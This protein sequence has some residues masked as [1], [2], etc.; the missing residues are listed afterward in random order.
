MKERPILFSGPMVNAILEGRKTQ[1][2]RVVKPQ[3]LR[4]HQPDS[5][6]YCLTDYS[7]DATRMFDHEH[8]RCPHG[9]QPEQ[10]WVRETF[11][12]DHDDYADGGRLPKGLPPI[13]AKQVLDSIYYRADGE[14]CQQ[15]PECQ[16]WDVGKPKWRPSIFMP[17]WASRITLEITGV[18]VER[19][20]NIS[21]NDAWSEGVTVEGFE[22]A[23]QAFRD[24]WDKINGKKHPWASNPWVWVVEFRRSE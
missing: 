9:M 21:E 19:L 15:I 10:L 17:R 3:P 11:Y 1:T 13:A 24:L 8:L 2:R 5:E 6:G 7:D 14:C 16:C 18:R 23:S 12:I 20:N 22:Y 4:M